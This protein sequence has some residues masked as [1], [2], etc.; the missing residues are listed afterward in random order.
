MVKFTT[1]F[2][3]ADRSSRTSPIKTAGGDRLLLVAVQKS[4]RTLRRGK[5]KYIYMRE[6][7][8]EIYWNRAQ[9]GIVFRPMGY[10][11]RTMGLYYDAFVGTPTQAEREWMSR[12]DYQR[13]G[14]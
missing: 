5:T 3:I 7:T 8:R 12:N 11:A 2:V 14:Q 13:V 4:R 1:S 6:G 10:D 9:N